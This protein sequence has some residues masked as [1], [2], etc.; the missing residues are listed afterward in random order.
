MRNALPHLGGWYDGIVGLVRELKGEYEITLSVYENDST[1]L[2]APNVECLLDAMRCG[3]IQS[4]FN[5]ETLGTERYGSVWN[6]NRLRNLANARQ[7]CLD[8][9]GDLSA[10]SKVAFI[11]PDVTHNP[12]WTKELIL[13]RHPRVAGLGEPDIYTGWSLR[14]EKNPKES[15]FLFDTSTTRATANDTCWDVNEV[16]GTW[17]GKTVIPTD[18]GGYDSMCLH[19]V[20]STFNC[21]CVYNAEPFKRGHKWTYWNR[22]INP[23]SGM[24]VPHPDGGTAYLEADTAAICETFHQYDFNKVFLNT[25]CLIRHT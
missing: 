21:F 5:S 6:V 13:A 17:R 20:W 10:F 12:S 15:I 22:R 9:V 19:P 3:G 25:N 8:Q 7:R 16:N 1:D 23:G 2:T 11:E 4:H 24:V 14:S 18:L